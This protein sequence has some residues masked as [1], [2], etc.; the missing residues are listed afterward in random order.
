MIRLRPKIETSVTWVISHSTRKLP[1]TEPAA[2]TRGSPAETRLPKTTSRT[3]IVIGIATDSASLRSSVMVSLTAAPTASAP[4][5]ATVSPPCWVPVAAMTVS[6][7][8]VRCVT[9]ASGSA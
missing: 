4:L 7:T 9:E 5:V 1:S 6:A 8:S 3:I 2:T